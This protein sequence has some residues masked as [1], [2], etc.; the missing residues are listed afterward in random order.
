MLAVLLLILKYAN[1]NYPLII[2]G[3]AYRKGKG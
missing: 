2:F 3:F 1:N